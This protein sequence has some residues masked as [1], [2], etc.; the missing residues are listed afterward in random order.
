MLETIVSKLM[1][2]FYLRHLTASAIIRLQYR[3]P[4]ECKGLKLTPKIDVYALGSVLYKILTGET[5]YH[6]PYVLPND[7]VHE[8]VKNGTPPT[9]PKQ[10]VK[11]YDPII[12]GIVDIMNKCHSLNPDDRPSSRYVADA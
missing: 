3:S 10:I 5:P 9:I 11:S 1:S 2:F 7:V 8:L 4:E 6:Y 12:V